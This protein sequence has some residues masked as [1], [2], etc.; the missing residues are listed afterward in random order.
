[1]IAE[2]H[3]RAARLT[4]LA[5]STAPATG[6]APAR[7]TTPPA[8]DILATDTAPATDTPRQAARGHWSPAGEMPF[9]GFW[10]PP[11]DA[12]VQLPD[13]RV[14]LAGGEDGRRV[15][16]DVTAL[17]DPAEGTWS[18]AG[19]LGT[20]RRLH[21]TT[22]LADGRVLVAGGIGEP[23]GPAPA[24]GLDS[25]EVYDPATDTW[26]GTG[27]LR[28]ARF[29]HSAT[30]LPDGRVL[31][32]GG[33]AVRSADSHRTLR[34]A[35]AYDPVAGT[36]T[37]VRP[38]TDARFGHPAVRFD[39][40]RV[41]MV[42]GILAVGRGSHTALAHCE[43]YD[44]AADGWTPTAGLATA[45]KSHQATLLP[46]NAVL[47]TGGDMRGF[48][49]DDWTYD[50]YSQ[51]TTERYD[52]TTDRW[53]AD[54][55]LPWGRSHHRAVRLATGDVLVAGGTDDASMAVG[56][57]NA[58]LY[59]AATRTWSAEFPMMR[60]RWAPAAIGLADGRVLVMG[61]LDESGPAAPLPG[62]DQVTA[63]AE[64]YTP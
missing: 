34:S 45:R 6:N 31:V 38:M 9:A 24:T 64:L 5:R 15:P 54:G 52:P 56:Y 8:G 13:G 19:A 44:P 58:T 37:P 14:L 48:V 41:L 55:Q 3:R 11:A 18:S 43:L 33:A 1:M 25:C 30:L 26:T 22:L 23:P 17:F 42:G 53:T 7:D 50:P 16:T 2:P 51:W 61:G 21:S 12:A 4:A 35:E 46:G 27:R 57:P 40:G 39:D 49:N 60:G 29:S 62:E 59:D 28:E 63:T 47:V 32:A 10:A 20:G 36:W